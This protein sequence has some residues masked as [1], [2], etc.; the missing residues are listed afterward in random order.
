ME[1]VLFEEEQKVL[2]PYASSGEQEIVQISFSDTS[3]VNDLN[4]RQK[5][6]VVREAVNMLYFLNQRKLNDSVKV[7]Q[8][9][10]TPNYGFVMVG[11]NSI[12]I[13]IEEFNRELEQNGGTS[14]EETLMKVTLHF[15]VKKF[16]ITEE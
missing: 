7:V 16:E 13:P 3:I 14:I 11:S 5:E 9:V 6:V 12:I 8:F 2:E 4:L 1:S 15:Y 10:Y